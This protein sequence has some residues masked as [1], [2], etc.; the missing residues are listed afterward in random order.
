[1]NC[2]DRA[3]EER[4]GLSRGPTPTVRNYHAHPELKIYARFTEEPPHDDRTRVS[5]RH[6]GAYRVYALIA[7]RRQGVLLSDS[8]LKS[9]SRLQ[10]R[11]LDHPT[12]VREDASLAINGSCYGKKGMAEPASTTMISQKHIHDVCKS[13]KSIYLKSC[14]R[15]QD[16]FRGKR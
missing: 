8:R 4:A 16:R 9:E 1:M 6:R 7:D 5:F 13:C 2:A 12:R 11:C 14:D 15:P 10:L 3:R